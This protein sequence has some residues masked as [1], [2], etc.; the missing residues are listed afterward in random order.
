M[1]T[2]DPGGRRTG[3]GYPRQPRRHV[4]PRA[5]LPEGCDAR[6]AARGSR[7]DP[8][9]DDQGRRAVAGGQLGRGLPPLHRTA[10]ARHR[11]ARHRRGDLLHRQP[12]GALLLPGSLHRRA[13]RHVGH[14]AQLFA[15]HG[16]P[17]AEEPVVAPDVRRVV[18]LPGARRRAH[19]PARR[20][21]RQPGRVAGVAARRARRDGD[22]RRNPQARQGH[23]DRSRPHGDRSARRRVAADHAR[24]RCGAAAGRRPHAV[25]GESRQPR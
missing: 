23:C 12:A 21:G 25:R 5:H 18:D 16:R 8:T 22:H 20:D 17:V 13:A 19:R 11:E 24:H 2:R 6:R 4:E 15:R 9:P 3:R 1:R 14:P 7:P 10:G